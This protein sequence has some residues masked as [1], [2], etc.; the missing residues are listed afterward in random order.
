MKMPQT[1]PPDKARTV[2]ASLIPENLN[3][4]WA[5]ISRQVLAAILAAA[6]LDEVPQIL[7]D[8]DRLDQI[9][10]KHPCQEGMQDSMIREGVIANIST[11]L[12]PYCRGHAGTGKSRGV[13]FTLADRL[14]KA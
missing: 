8:R 5:S 14:N 1:M 6:P 12:G 3:Q 13:A 10:E 2:A 7:D 11:A 9:L 4:F